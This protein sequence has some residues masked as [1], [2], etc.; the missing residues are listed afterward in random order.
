MDDI[1]IVGQS[2]FWS[3][4][5]L[6]KPDVRVHVVDT[7]TT[8]LPA[9]ASAASLVTVSDLDSIDQLTWAA[10][11]MHAAGVVPVAVNVSGEMAQLSRPTSRRL[12][13]LLTR[14]RDSLLE[15]AT[16]AS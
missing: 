1:V 6:R 14:P 10:G 13:V 9:F 2:E 7:A 15:P 8:L 5:L 11:R 3:G 16:S 4:H 12:W